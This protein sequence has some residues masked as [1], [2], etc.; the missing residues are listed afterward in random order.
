MKCFEVIGGKVIAGISISKPIG[1]PAAYALVGQRV[2]ARSPFG[3]QHWEDGIK[4]PLTEALMRSV[5]LADAR[6]SQAEL[7]AQEDG[8]YAFDV[9]TN[10]EAVIVL[11]GVAASGSLRYEIGVPKVPERTVVRYYSD[12]H[13][14]YFFRRYPF[15]LTSLRAGESISAGGYVRTLR[16]GTER[17]LRHPFRREVYD[18]CLRSCGEVR[19]DGENV[20]FEAPPSTV[21]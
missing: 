20:V 1:A 11:Y 8:T 4:V 12:L 7:V 17:T 5:M 19:Y 9:A 13:G 16:A 21:D 2:T 3:V 18:D 6:L 10:D 15:I 14:L